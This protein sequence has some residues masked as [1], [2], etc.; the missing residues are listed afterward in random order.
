MSFSGGMLESDL[1]L[2]NSGDPPAIFIHGSSDTI[3]PPGDSRQVY[4]R[5]K[6]QQVKTE[7]FTFPGGHG[8]FP[9]GH[10]HVRNFLLS[11]PPAPNP[12]QADFN[13]DGR[14]DLTDYN[15]LVVG[16]GSQYNLS[17]YNQLIT[18]YGR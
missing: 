8:P 18:K 9:G 5:L 2:I 14:V 3:V 15:I 16:Y 7:Y 13:H 17:H 12:V 1:N 11:L 6:I 4:D 10:L